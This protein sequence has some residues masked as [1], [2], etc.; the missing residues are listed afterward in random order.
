MQGNVT[1]VAVRPGIG[2]AGKVK[3]SVDGEVVGRFRQGT[4]LDVPLAAGSHR[5][6]VSSGGCRSK[7]VDVTV[8]EGGVGLA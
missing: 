2:R 1:V 3:V 8:V 4:S 7:N 6:R 5:F